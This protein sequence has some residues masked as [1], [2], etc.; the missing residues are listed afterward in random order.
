MSN[1]W[2][3]YDYGFIVT[4]SHIGGKMPFVGPR[5]I[6]KEMEEALHSGQGLA[7]KMYDD[8]DELYYEGKFVGDE[9]QIMS[10][11]FDYG[12]PNAGCTYMKY[13]IDGKWV[14][15]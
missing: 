9:T 12:M 11:L 1:Y 7:F 5:D 4:K 10:P 14:V 6:P 3:E 15:I 8:D 13:N 2:V